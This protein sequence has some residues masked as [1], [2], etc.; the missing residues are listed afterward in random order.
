VRRERSDVRCSRADVFGDGPRRPTSR[1]VRSGV[2]LMP[3][4]ARAPTL[5]PAGRQYPADR[6]IGCAISMAMRRCQ[7]R[8][9]DR[10]VPAEDV[11]SL[12]SRIVAATRRR[13]GSLSAVAAV[14]F[15]RTGSAPPALIG[16]DDLQHQSCE[17]IRRNQHV[18]HHGAHDGGSQMLGSRIRRNAANRNLAAGADR[19]ADVVDGGLG[20]V[21]LCVV[22]C[23]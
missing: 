11:Q 21:G 2:R 15:V 6:R 16:Q 12:E 20:A 9:N 1:W 17:C 3:P 4:S 13:T 19:E 14:A 10:Y 23:V 5:C 7:R 22:L 8:S 18:R